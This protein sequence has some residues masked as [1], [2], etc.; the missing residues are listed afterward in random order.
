MKIIFLI[1][2]IIFSA[3]VIFSQ[4]VDKTNL[5][6]MAG[7]SMP[8]GS[9]SFSEIHKTG[10]NFNINVDHTI[11]E[12]LVLGGE[13]DFARQPGTKTDITPIAA[14][15]KDDSYQFID[16]N[17]YVKLQNNLAKKNE[18]QLF[19]KAGGGVFMTSVN[20]ALGGGGTVILLGPGLNFMAGHDIKITSGVEYRY[21]F[22]KNT[23]WSA[24][25]LQFKVGFS[26]CLNPR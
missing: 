10:F 26:F 16:L 14:Y 7:F 19:F 11:S 17:A 21:H 15:V 3:D 5:G 4:G 13:L 8:V 12:S 22:S 25:L 23:D 1:F 6:F 20:K 9:K 24:S 18:V 2:C